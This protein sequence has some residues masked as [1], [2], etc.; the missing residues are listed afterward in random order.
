MFA[1]VSNRSFQKS[2]APAPQQKKKQRR[3]SKDYGGRFPPFVALFDIF[4]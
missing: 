4:I 2:V 1:E 3:S